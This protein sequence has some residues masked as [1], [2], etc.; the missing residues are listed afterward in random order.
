MPVGNKNQAKNES[1]NIK[2]QHISIEIV[3]LFNLFLKGD[4]NAALLLFNTFNKRIYLYCAKIV[5]NTYIAEDI[6]QEVWERIIKLRF[7]EG[8]NILNPIGFIFT[9]ARNL[10]LNHIKLQ[11]QIISLDSLDDFRLPSVHQPGSTSVEE[12]VN[13]SLNALKFEDR[14]LLVLHMYCGYRFDEIAE[15][16]N[17][18]PNAVW[19]RASRAR[20]QL[21]EIISRYQ[22]NDNNI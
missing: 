3:E 5:S 6:T 17:I 18:S 11:K 1:P 15:M 14:E 22:R 16:L 20:A 2:E 7:Q 13:T 21:R 4:D 9:I 10:C 12:L 8:T 19:T